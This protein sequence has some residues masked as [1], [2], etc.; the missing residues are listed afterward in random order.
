MCLRGSREIVQPKVWIKYFNACLHFDAENLCE[1]ILLC[2]IFESLNWLHLVSIIAVILNEIPVN[3]N[4]IQNRICFVWY[5]IHWFKMSHSFK[6]WTTKWAIKNIVIDKMCKKHTIF[7]IFWT[8]DDRPTDIAECRR[9][10]FKVQS[11][12]LTKLWSGVNY[13]W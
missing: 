10:M 13:N 8:F 12:N 1:T 9:F 5:S 11:Q 3:L 2:M 7:S 6:K 4:I